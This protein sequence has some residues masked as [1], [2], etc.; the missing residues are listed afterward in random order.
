MWNELS[1]MYLF[2]CEW[3]RCCAVHGRVRW[4]LVDQRK[5]K[6]GVE[7]SC[8]FLNC[9]DGLRTMDPLNHLTSTMGG[10]WHLYV[11]EDPVHFILPDIEIWSI[12]KYKRNLHQ[13]ICF[14]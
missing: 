12:L 4:G 10:T 14:G 9:A 7:S 1:S 2:S 5:V 11:S 3:I 13:R 8:H 6:H